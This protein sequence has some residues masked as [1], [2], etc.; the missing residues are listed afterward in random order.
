MIHSNQPETS[1]TALCSTTG[2]F[3][4]GSHGSGPT[5][6]FP[7]HGGGK[8]EH[9]ESS[10]QAVLESLA[11]QRRAIFIR[12]DS[13]VTLAMSRQLSSST[14]SSN[15]VGGE[16]SILLEEYGIIR[17]AG[18]EPAARL[19][20]Q[21][22]MTEPRIHLPACRRSRSAS[23]LPSWSMTLSCSRRVP[24][25]RPGRVCP[26]TTSPCFTACETGST[27]ATVLQ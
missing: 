11:I 23:C 8:V 22:R 12:S 16:L 14:P 27:A 2:T 7:V 15:H 19:A 26:L 20:V 9:G 25:K 4:G 3:F 10:S 5:G 24:S 17:L 1:A 13:V 21:T 18:N 6:E